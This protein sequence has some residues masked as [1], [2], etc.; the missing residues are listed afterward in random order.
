MDQTKKDILK[1]VYLVYLVLFIFAI[2]IAGKVAYIQF[3]E[4][5]ELLEKAQEYELRFFSR[6]AI[7][8]NIYASDGNLLAT[9]VPIFDLRMDVASSNISDK[10]FKES[11]DSL[12]LGLS[13]IFRNKPSGDYKRALMSARKNGNRYYLIKRDITYAQLKEVKKLPLLRLGRFRGG[14]IAVQKSRRQLPFDLLARRTIGYVDIDDSIYVGLE[15]AYSGV[16]SGQDG[17]QLMRRVNHGDWIPVRDENEIEPR[18]GHDL[19]TTIDVDIQDV[20]EYALKQ[21]LEDQGAHHGSVV[22]M[23]VSTGKVKAIA[24][25]KY[26]SVKKDYYEVYNYAVGEAFEPGS[27]FKLAS[28]LVLLE[29]KK[30]NLRDTIDIGEGWTVYYGHT[31]NDVHPIRNGRISVREAF[32]KSSNVGMSKVVTAYFMKEP[33]RFV[34]HLY[35][36]GLNNSLGIE[37]PGEQAP[38]IKHPDDNQFWYGTSLPWMAIGYELELTPLQILSFYNAIANNGKMVRPMFVE[39]IQHAGITTEEFEPVVIKKSICSKSTL[40]T[41]QSLLEGVV[42]RGTAKSLGKSIYK[43]AGKTGTAQI[44]QGNTG[45]DK[46]NYNSSFV[47]YF[48]ADDPK[49]SCIV[50]VNRPTKGLYY[51]SSVAAPVFKEIADKVYATQLDIPMN[52]AFEGDKI[53][54]PLYQVGKTEEFKTVINTLSIPADTS[55]VESEWAV[56]LPDDDKIKLAT[57][58]IKKNEV[59]NVKGMSA[60]DA[61]YILEQLGMKTM[62]RGRGMV[63]DQSIVPGQIIEKGKTIVLELSII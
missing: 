33:E 22:L 26:D 24:N 23:E 30:I 53:Q 48:P 38:Y 16:L 36:M 25:L 52:Y 63:K 8:G 57:R 34:N 39:G 10:L 28:M 2:T 51:G 58:L 49:Y 54:Y 60:E 47:G 19:I 41:I 20:A 9:S 45:Y 59:P 4:G 37:I 29:D 3:A 7:R 1:R 44:A 18:N 6:E 17:K 12:A 61:I 62:I 21:H 27:T 43:I 42:K 50:V 32:E 13:K 11:I 35:D 31:L 55:N 5:D 56:I 14:L 15:G 40:D 46:S